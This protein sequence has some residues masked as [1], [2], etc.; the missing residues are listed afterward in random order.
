MSHD[1]SQESRQR[2]RKLANSTNIMTL[3]SDLQQ[4]LDVID[5]LR[6]ELA[7]SARGEVWQHEIDQPLP[8]DAEID[9]AFPTRSGDHESYNEAHRLVSAKYSKGALVA[10]VNWLLVKLKSR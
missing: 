9:A 10:L 8:E 1:L 5:A 7:K 6:Y 3:R 2:L 4:A